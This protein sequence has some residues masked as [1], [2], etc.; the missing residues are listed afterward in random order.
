MPQLQQR[1]ILATSVTY[2]TA[3]CNV[4]SLTHWARPRIEPASSWI[5][6]RFVNCWG[7]AG[8]PVASA[9]WSYISKCQWSRSFTFITYFAISCVYLR[10][11]QKQLQFTVIRLGKAFIRHTLCQENP[12]FVLENKW[13]VFYKIKL[14][15]FSNFEYFLLLYFFIFDV[16]RR[17][18][19]LK[20]IWGCRYPVDEKWYNSLELSWNAIYAAKILL[21]SEILPRSSNFL[22]VLS[23]SCYVNIRQMK[24]ALLILNMHCF[25]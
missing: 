13:H 25:L 19:N 11:V 10:N 15:S 20:L 18:N 1:W 4:T 8:T 24:V 14:N 6:V 7:T 3:H 2:T 12:I 5:L 9:L 21:E 16:R 17:E 23:F 22:V